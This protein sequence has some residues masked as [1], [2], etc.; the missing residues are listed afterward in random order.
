MA[1]RGGSSS[2]SS[3][4]GDGSGSGGGMEVVVE[5]WSGSRGA[6]VTAAVMG[7]IVAVGEGW[8][9][10]GTGGCLVPQ[11]SEGLAFSLKSLGT[12]ALVS[13]SV[14]HLTILQGH[15]L[16]TQYSSVVFLTAC[17]VV[18]MHACFPE[19]DLEFLWSAGM[20]K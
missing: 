10:G 19:E 16:H 11:Q 4:R 2:S 1:G 3:G 8:W 13:Q 20:H 6:V 5:G 18:T 17:W 12:P 15:A 14:N 7:L 9:D